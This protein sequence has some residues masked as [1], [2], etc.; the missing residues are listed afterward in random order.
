MRLRYL[1]MSLSVFG[2]LQAAETTY[3]VNCEGFNVETKTRVIGTCS[4]AHFDGNDTVSGKKAYGDCS[5]G[6]NLDGYDSE[7]GIAI[8]G[9]CEGF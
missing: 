4:Q 6:G 8:Y 1:I 5:P 9:E 2:L 7:T 3:I